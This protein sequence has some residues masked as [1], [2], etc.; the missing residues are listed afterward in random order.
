MPNLQLTLVSKEIAIRLKEHKKTIAI[1]FDGVIHKYSKGW[2]DGSIYDEPMDGVFEAIQ[3]LFQEGYT[4]FI[5]STRKSRQIKRWLN[6]HI[7]QSE[8][9][10]VGLGDPQD[11]SYPKYGYR[12]SII[13]FWK[14]FWNKENVVGITNRKL[15]AYVYIDDR[16][17]KFE[18]SWKVTLTQI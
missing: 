17:L 15:P 4:V 16:A 9:V 7:M 13:P 8:W 12:C 10:G 18:G 2:M 14:K 11:Y 5:F 6:N 1:D 3:Q